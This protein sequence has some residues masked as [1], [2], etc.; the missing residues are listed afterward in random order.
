MVCQELPSI[1]ARCYS[2]NV[3]SKWPLKTCLLHVQAFWLHAFSKRDQSVATLSWSPGI[4][5][6]IS[7]WERVAIIPQLHLHNKYTV[8]T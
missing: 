7:K 2:M 1:P 8:C 5:S 4:G 3:C 6:R